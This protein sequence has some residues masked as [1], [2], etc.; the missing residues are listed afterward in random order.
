MRQ[1]DEVS[2]ALQLPS[3][4]AST[5][6]GIEKRAEIVHLTHSPPFVPGSFNRL[7]GAQIQKITE[8]RQVAISFWEGQRPERED[9][10]GNVI[11]VDS[12]PLSL[13]KKGYLH[14]PRHLQIRSRRFNGLTG[15]SLIYIWQVLKILPKLRPKIIVCYDNHWLGPLLRQ[16]VNWPC[17]LVLSQHGLSYHLS[18]R[19]ADRV[20]SLESFDV[21]WALTLAS[22]RYDRHRMHAYEPSV[23]IL[24]NGVDVEKYK[25]ASTAE[26][27]NYRRQWSLPQDKLIVLL[28][29][30]LVPK[31]GAH[32]IVQSWPKILQQIP[33]AYLWIAGSGNQDYENY[34]KGLIDALQISDSVRLQG[35]IPPDLTASCN[36]A[37]D[38]YVFPTLANEAM[39]LSLLEAMSCGLACVTSEY[40]AAR[41]LYSDG[42]VLFVPDPNL[43]GSFVEP[44]VRLLRD[45]ALRKRLGE[46]ARETAQ[47]RYSHEVSFAQIKEF[48]REQLSLVGYKDFRSDDLPVAGM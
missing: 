47:Q 8:Y 40:A 17:R 15:E 48:Y 39:G 24:P 23:K 5:L 6:N 35:A 30:R 27:Q 43:E 33:N 11:L 21:I 46:S 36:Q 1:I 38:L 9:Y 19:H 37:S 2:P 42:E 22:Y 12:N 31:K 26:K 32:L 16:G 28:L 41:E 20:Y 10:N 7:I 18:G 29:S 14:L 25:P 3:E 34:L 4:E 45:A 13:W 44:V